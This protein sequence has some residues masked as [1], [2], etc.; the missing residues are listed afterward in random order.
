MELLIHISIFIVLHCFPL[1]P[2]SDV[3]WPIRMINEAWKFLRKLFSLSSRISLDFWHYQQTKPKRPEEN[4]NK[5]SAM[6]DGTGRRARGGNTK[7]FHEIKKAIERA[8]KP[9]QNRVIALEWSIVAALSSSWSRGRFFISARK[10][11]SG[12]ANGSEKTKMLEIMFCRLTIERMRYALVAALCFHISP[13]LD[14][15][16]LSTSSTTLFRAF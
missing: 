15:K 5:A 10:S 2:R 16:P 14:G 4:G 7:L 1:S 8:A 9:R 6:L 12:S 11:K 3:T 13:A